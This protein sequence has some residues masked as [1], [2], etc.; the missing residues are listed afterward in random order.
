MT[1]LPHITVCICTY[2]R[3]ELLKR[4][5]E[6]LNRQETSGLFTF[7]AVVVDNDALQSAETVVGQ[8]ASRLAFPVQYVVEPRQ[9]ISLARNKAVATSQGDYLALIDDDE[10]PSE[11]WLITLFTDCNRWGSDGVLGP[12]KPHFDEPPPDWVIR[13]SFYDRQ[14]LA[15][16]KILQWYDCRTGNALL[17]SHVFAG[18]QQPFRPE[19]RGGED[20]DFFRRKIEQGYQFMW[21]SNATV[22]ELVPPVRWQRRFMLRRAL[23]RGAVTVVHRPGPIE[24]LKSMIAVPIYTAALPITLLIG[25]HRFMEVLI[26]LFD[27]LGKLLAL[28]GL[29]PVKEPYVTQ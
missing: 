12:V 26:R 5:L 21:C 2:R 15:A 24:I 1:K 16:G 18:D 11:T 29:N 19:L 13:G 17:R 9:N 20:R 22:R 6:A 8:C 25:H 3:R 10:F 14:D 7:S 27:H 23:L 28:V 4:L